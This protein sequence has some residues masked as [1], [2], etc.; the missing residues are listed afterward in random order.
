MCIERGKYG[1]VVSV[2]TREEAVF[3]PLTI[4]K[5]KAISVEVVWITRRILHRVFP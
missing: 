3:R 1:L 2:S 5:D 4:G